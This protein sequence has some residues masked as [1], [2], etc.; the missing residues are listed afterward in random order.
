MLRMTLIGRVIDG[1]PLAASMEDE[2]TDRELA[3]YKSQAKMILKRL[4]DAS[5]QRCTIETGPFFFHYVIEIG[6]CYLVMCDKSYPK[7]LAFDY[8]SD[9]QREFH[10][11]YANEVTTAARP[12]VFIDFDTVI[13]KTKKM[14]MDS[15]SSKNLAKLNDELQDVHRIMTQNIQDVIGRGEK[16]DKVSALAGNLSA[17]SKKYLKDA[18][19]L[20]FLNAFYR[21]YGP[22]GVV[23]V[24]LVVVIYLRYYVFY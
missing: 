1:L 15:R 13:Q 16:I 11:R 10:N 18:K 9:L 17:E 7:K 19:Y 12:W 14:Y 2:Q 24:T 8:L 5:P 3:E 23:F 22:L 6:V 4:S 21:K 20:N